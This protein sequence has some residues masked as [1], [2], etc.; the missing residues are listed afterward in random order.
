MLKL[1]SRHNKTLEEIF[2]LPIK[3]NIQWRDAESMLVALGAEL[4]EGN[5]SRVR[6]YS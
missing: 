5:G 3:S 1:S 4:E 6:I 2:S